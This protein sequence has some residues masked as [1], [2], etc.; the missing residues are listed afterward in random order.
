M[1]YLAVWG[2]STVP[3]R[4]YGTDG[5]NIGPRILRVRALSIKQ[6]KFACTIVYLMTQHLR[7]AEQIPKFGLKY[8][9]AQLLAISVKCGLS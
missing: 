6:F 9:Q 2:H 8:L 5:S 4:R 3:W 1:E 7:D